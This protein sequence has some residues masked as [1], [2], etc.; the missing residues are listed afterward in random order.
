M[1]NSIAP[2]ETVAS[3]KYDR[4]IKPEAGAKVATSSGKYNSLAGPTSPAKN[5]PYII[6]REDGYKVLPANPRPAEDEPKET[7]SETLNTPPP[8]TIF[9]PYD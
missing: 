3:G 2:Q 6:N 9:N 5:N 7:K 4:L 1:P 8:S